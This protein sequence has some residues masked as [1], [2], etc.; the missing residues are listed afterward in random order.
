[1]TAA[2]PPEP[3]RFQAPTRPVPLHA[4]VEVLALIARQA[5]KVPWP[6]G[7]AAIFVLAIT[8]HQVPHAALLIWTAAVIGMQIV[9]RSVLP[10]LPSRAMSHAAR[11]RTAIWLSGIN[12]VAQGSAVLFFYTMTDLQRAIVS[13]LL[14]GIT[15]GAIGTT[16]GHPRIYN[17]FAYPVMLGLTLSW[18][19]SP[20]A[21]AVWWIDA[22]MSFLCLAFLI[23]Q[24]GLA[25]DQYRSL[26][27]S[28]AM[29]NAQMQLNE[30]LRGALQTA[31]EANAAKTRFLAS[32][33]HDLRQPLHTL[34][35]FS[36]ALQQSPEL[37][38]SA[39]EIAQHMDR[40]IRNL[41]EQLSGLLDLSK[42]DAG[43]VEARRQVLRLSEVL[44]PMTQ[45]Y[46][47]EA[48]SRG[49]TFTVQCDDSLCIDSDKLLLGRVIR[50]L[51]DNAFK[52]SQHG[53]ITVTT[54]RQGD[55]VVM[56]IKDEG[57]GI[58]HAMQQH[59]FEEFFQVSNPERDQRKGL[60]LG[61]SIVKRL[62]S[63]LHIDMELWSEPGLGTRV[64]LSLP[65]GDE[66][67][68]PRMHHEPALPSALPELNV[69]V[70]D[71]EADTRLAMQTLLRTMGC[72]PLLADGTEAA[73]QMASATP[74]D[75]VLA[76]FRLRGDD[77]G[78]QAIQQLRIQ[79]PGLPALL[80]S[81]DVAQDRL[82]QA[83]AAGLRMLHKPVTAPVLLQAIIETLTESEPSQS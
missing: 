18:A 54:Q 66:A 52:Y 37:P 46:A 11:M 75:I 64:V 48:D 63:L 24:S 73:L 29:R 49:L 21:G 23:V 47:A 39:R 1:M 20:H 65:A 55:R 58:P 67:R 16:N 45:E 30:Q 25:R 26:S 62:C 22:T 38:T 59:V 56:A 50:N 76:D 4:E 69:L 57:C 28:V 53:T 41:G 80:I 79:H 36:A 15:A 82:Q 5:H 31:E 72:T 27:E 74:P 7:L 32:A 34:T 83:H 43:I 77:S 40:T 81:G 61:L 35:L 12:G 78:L 60:G 19:L 71:D 51:L 9:R 6:V 70:V 13:I 10:G 44:R 8:W 14:S 33:S 17:A 3:T 2:T 42:L 68:L